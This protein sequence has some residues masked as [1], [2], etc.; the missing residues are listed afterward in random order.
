MRGDRDP[1]ITVSCRGDR[2]PLIT[3]SCR[4]DRDPLI[5]V[6]C[7]SDMDPLITRYMTLQMIWTK[8]VL[9]AEEKYLRRLEIDRDRG[10]GP[11]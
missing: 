6:S 3:V 10:Q 4:G 9:E 5:T 1:L 11:T 7:R 8:Q 2:D